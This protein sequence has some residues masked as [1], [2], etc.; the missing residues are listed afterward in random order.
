MRFIAIFAVFFLFFTGKSFA[1]GRC[2]DGYFPI[3]GGDAGWEGCAPM[4]PAEELPSHQQ[5]QPK[6]ETRWGAIAT[7]G[8]GFG[9]VGNLASE[10]EA[11]SLAMIRCRETATGDPSRCKV[12]TYYNQC[13][14]LAWGLTGSV[15]QSA[16][17]LQTAS[18]MAVDKC[19]ALSE[20]CQVYYNNCSYA[21]LVD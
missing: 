17:D 14:V 16:V 9:G 5:S 12:Q 11:A 6:W 18:R 2:P 7:G 3:G 4:G 15:I 21:E 13:A 20:D 19:S 10:S 1:E 8:S